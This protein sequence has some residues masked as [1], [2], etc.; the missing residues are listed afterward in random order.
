MKKL[1]I[2]SKKF[3][4]CE[5]VEQNNELFIKIEQE[6]KIKQKHK[7]DELKRCVKLG[8][9]IGNAIN[10]IGLDK[11]QKE[12]TAHKWFNSFL[13]LEASLKRREDNGEVL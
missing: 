9:L 11:R 2:N 5:F 10:L 6:D 12:V 13:W 8:K 7:K 3:G 4:K 1:V